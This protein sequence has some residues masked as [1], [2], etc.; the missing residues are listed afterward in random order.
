MRKILEQQRKFFNDGNTLSFKTRKRY[1]LTLKEK[2]KEYENELYDGIYRDLNKSKT[3]TYMCEIGLVLNDISYQ[4]KHLNKNGRIKKKK[5]PLSQFKSKSYILPVPY[6]NTLIISPWNYPILLS[7]QPLVGAIASGNTTILKLSEYSRNTNEVIIKIINKVFPKEY[8]SI[9]LGDYKVAE[10]LL[11]LDFDYIF[12]TGSINVGK[13]VAIAAGEKLIPTTL[14]LGGKSPVIVDETAKLDLAC[15]RII[16]GKY[17]NSGQTCVAPDYIIVKDEIKDKLIHTLIK[18]INLLYPD[19]LNNLDY[20]KII[21]EKHFERLLNY[22]NSSNVI[23]GGKYDRAKLKIEPTLVLGTLESKVM[24]EEIF[25]PI[26]PILEYSN[27]NDLLSIIKRNPNPLALY[28]FSNNKKNINFITKNISFGGGCI[29]DTVIHLANHNIAFGG[30][31]Q[32]G[33]GSY[34]GDKSF[35]T[36]SHYKSILKKA[37]WL[38]L[39]MRYTPY[40]KNKDK[41]IKMFLK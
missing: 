10:E 18:Y 17:L 36:F 29:N 33:I 28:L 4:I 35:E 1:L 15:K 19:S 14:E 34:H 9:V 26:L 30:I 20:V 38:D 13:K 3:E 37:N 8:V 2:I 40:T 22:I 6:G 24:Q 32:S 39:P 27:N 41:I 23:F 31:R 25:G 11:K 21:N 5:T 7:L 12:F 16:F